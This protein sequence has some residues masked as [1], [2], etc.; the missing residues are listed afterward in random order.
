VDFIQAL[1]LHWRLRKKLEMIRLYRFSDTVGHAIIKKLQ[2]RFGKHFHLHDRADDLVEC[3]K[4]RG[5]KSE[6]KEAKMVRSP[7]LQ[8]MITK[9]KYIKV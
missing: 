2:K 6:N 4:N 1:I 3:E 9:T 5:K 8:R 7:K